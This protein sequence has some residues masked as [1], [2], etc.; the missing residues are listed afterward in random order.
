MIIEVTKEDIDRGRKSDGRRCPMA[1][2]VIRIFG[3]QDDSVRVTSYQTK[4]GGERY[5]HSKRLQTVIESYDRCNQFRA[6]RYR[7]KKR[8]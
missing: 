1:R 8:T 6:G 5:I 2:A 4:M 7:I 3:R